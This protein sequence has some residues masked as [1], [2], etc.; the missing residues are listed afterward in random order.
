MAPMTRL[1]GFNPVSYTHLFFFINEDSE[2]GIW[3][4]KLKHDGKYFQYVTH[5]EIE[6]GKIYETDSKF[7]HINEK[8]PL[9]LKEYIVSNS[10]DLKNIKF[11]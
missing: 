2:D 3:C 10:P 4:V 11:A 9:K 5:I 6:P 7:R 8:M 1:V